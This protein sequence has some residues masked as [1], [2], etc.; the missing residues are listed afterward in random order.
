[1]AASGITSGYT[2]NTYRPDISVTRGHFS[3]FTARTLDPS[4]RSALAATIYGN[5]LIDFNNHPAWT[6]Y[7]SSQA[8]GDF[9]NYRVLQGENRLK[10]DNAGRLS[11]ELP[12]GSLGSSQGGGIIKADIAKK[13][14]YTFEYEVRFD[15]NFP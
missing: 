3:A 13:D 8:T 2:D 1:M 12:K 14:T 15:Q 9:G 10:I 6:V 4:F 5:R 11:F 7:G